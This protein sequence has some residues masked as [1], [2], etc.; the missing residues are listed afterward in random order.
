MHIGSGASLF[1]ASSGAC[2]KFWIIVR[3]KPGLSTLPRTVL[4]LLTLC[5]FFAS[6]LLEQT[7]ADS[8]RAAVTAREYVAFFDREFMRRS[9]RQMSDCINAALGT[10][11]PRLMLFFGL[12]AFH[13]NPSAWFTPLGNVLMAANA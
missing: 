6:T 8:V 11:V 13:E 2:F 10:R 1:I 12:V 5:L 7:K 9:M 3:K 4:A